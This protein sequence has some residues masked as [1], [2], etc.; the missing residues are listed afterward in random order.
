MGL[1][2]SRVAASIRSTV[3][4]SAALLPAINTNICSIAT[5]IEICDIVVTAC[6][7]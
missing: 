5:G 7:G 6:Y 1:A 3:A 4:L 2:T